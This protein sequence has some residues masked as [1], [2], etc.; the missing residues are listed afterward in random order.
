M[1]KILTDTDVIIDF[2]RGYHLRTKTVF[3]QIKNLEIKAYISLISIVELYAGI[4]KENN[5]QE[6]NL[7]KLLSLLE[8]LPIDFDLSKSAGGLRRKHHLSITDSVIAATSSQYKIK[9]FTF[10]VK[11]FSKLPEVELYGLTS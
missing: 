7:K 1:E 6:E 11:H 3:S 4:E 2:L 10:N 8:V 5:Q 9:L